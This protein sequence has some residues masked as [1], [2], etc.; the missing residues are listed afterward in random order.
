MNGGENKKV[1]LLISSLNAATHRDI[2]KA[3]NEFGWF[4]DLS[5]IEGGQLP[6]RWSG[7]GILCSLTAHPGMEK[8]VR[9]TALPVVDISI[10]KS[11]LNLPR[12]VADNEKIGRTA[13]EHLLE[14]EHR[15]FAW[16]SRTD[17]PVASVRF[18]GFQK[19]VASEV[20]KLSG[21][22]NAVA[23]QLKQL[24]RP[25]G[26]FAKTDVDAAWIMSLCLKEGYRVPED[27]AIV[28]VDNNPLICDFLQVPLTSVN[29]DLE[30]LGYQAACLLNRL[31]QG[32]K[33]PNEITLIPPHGVTPRASTDSFAVQDDAVRAAMI[34]M[35]ERLGRS[36]GTQEIAK[37]VG[38]SRRA[39]ELRFKEAV[40]VTVHEQLMELRLNRAE[41]LLRTSTDSAET[42]AALTGFCH[43]QH[44]SRLFKKRFGEPP[45]RYRKTL[46]A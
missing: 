26:I 5:F 39:L 32:E 31:M 20:I 46:R 37:A 4:L 34:F 8:F 45:L 9:K 33:P 12:V 43:A 1:L 11:N 13:A 3:A 44:L 22:W 25:C 42:I 36:I 35:K 10:W 17:D 7:D 15:H 21:D 27:F 14:Q 28:G 23:N 18:G 29:H 24:S 41:H 19:R 40:G 30:Q 16:F 38:L 2:A 6:P